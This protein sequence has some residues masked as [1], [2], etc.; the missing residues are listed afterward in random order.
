MSNSS[1]EVLNM[2]SLTISKQLQEAE[3]FPKL[4][5]SSMVGGYLVTAILPLEKLYS[6]ALCMAVYLSGRF[7]FP[8]LRSSC[9]VLVL[10]KRLAESGNNISRKPTQQNCLRSYCLPVV[11]ACPVHDVPVFLSRGE[12]PISALSFSWHCHKK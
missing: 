6:I 11:S 3:N 1:S 9:C 5:K 2:M 12:I 10:G 7:F 8:L 4:L